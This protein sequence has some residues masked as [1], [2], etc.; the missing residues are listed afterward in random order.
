[1]PGILKDEHE[2]L[3]SALNAWLE[4]DREERRKV[5]NSLRLRRLSCSTAAMNPER[6]PVQISQ[7]TVCHCPRKRS[8]WLEPLPQLVKWL[9]KFVRLLRG[10]PVRTTKRD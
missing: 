9:R 6:R 7:Q 1:L 5:D 4:V 3:V 2:K 10:T 8:R